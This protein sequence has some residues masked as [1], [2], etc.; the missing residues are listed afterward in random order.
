MG[1]DLSEA[2]DYWCDRIRA[3]GCVW[4]IVKTDHESKLGEYQ[5]LSYQMIN[6][7]PCS[8]DD[9]KAIAQDSIDYVELIKSN[10][11]EFEKF[12]RKNANEINHYEMLADLYRHNKEF[13]ECKWFRE[14][15]RK[16]IS[17][18]VHKLRKGKIFVEGDN[19]TVFGNPYALL[20]HS[21]GEN[22]K[23]DPTFCKE[24]GCIQCYTPRFNSNEYLAAF[25][26]P[27]NSPN[28][29]CYMH[30]MYSKYFERYFEFSNNIM[31]VNCIETDVQDRCNGEDF[32]SDF[33]LVTNHPTI[34][35]CAKICYE[36]YPTIV[37]SL[38]ESG[39][40]YGSSKTDYSNMDNKFSGSQMG[41]GWSS[42][43]A[44]LGMTYFWTELAKES[45]DEN[46]L[47]ELYDNF[48]ILSVLAQVIID[49]CK[50]VYEIDG[51][52]EIKR[53]SQLP[54]MSL[55]KTVE[56]DGKCKT[57][58]CDFPE[59][60][61]YT[62]EIKSTKDG[63]ELPPEVVN[64]NKS[65]LLSRINSDLQCPMNWLQDWLDKIQNISSNNAV[66]TKDFFV[67]MQ[68]KANDR[69][70][71]KIRKLVESYDGYIKYYTLNCN[72]NNYNVGEMVSVSREILDKLCKIKIG[73]IITINRLIETALGLE[74]N[75]NRS[76][77]YK[78]G[79][80]YTRKMLNLLYRMDRNKFLNNFI[81]EK[82]TKIT[83]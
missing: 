46:R 34:V 50:R 45:P 64:K 69:Q 30:N 20:L 61:R 26:N 65:K 70:M 24:D 33:N 14:E 73:N 48:V 60:M 15:K 4:G 78:D 67:K 41:I 42:N 16:I 63:K 76:L 31:A 29:V 18:Y 80:K 43:L 54:C 25:R 10:N 32:D 57:I 19:L 71:S 51:E 75:N 79:Q 47:K 13:A 83:E 66:P 3:D 68:G 7:L 81:C 23:D 11:D 40:T 62:K 12:L 74:T 44:Q 59:F 37:N 77:F 36:N 82:Y 28:N 6:T 72:D 21:V 27:H 22:W 56:E 53:I 52:D 5:Q 39:M 8:K 58:K 9:V 2:Y 17:N 1:N 38:N 55:T 49:G 35:K